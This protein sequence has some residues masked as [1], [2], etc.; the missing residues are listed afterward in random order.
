MLFFFCL[1]F[2]KGR[3]YLNVQSVAFFAG[4]GLEPVQCNIN[5][6]RV[7]FGWD[8]GGF[9]I[10]C[11]MY[12]IHIECVSEK[13]LARKGLEIGGRGCCPDVAEPESSPDVVI[14]YLFCLDLK[15]PRDHNRTQNLEIGTS[16]LECLTQCLSLSKDL[17]KTLND[18]FPRLR[19]DS[20]EEGDN[21]H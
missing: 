11:M 13:D 14:L 9:N 3:C 21:A 4:E 7:G 15:T 2:L 5:S 18:D 12:V 20:W 10:A 6:M 19:F 17:S 8:V 16:N 1:F